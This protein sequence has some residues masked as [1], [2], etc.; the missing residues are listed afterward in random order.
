[1]QV[2]VHMG[3]HGLYSTTTEY[4]KFIR[5]WLNDGAAPDGSQ[6]LKPE[7][8]AMASENHL[9]GDMKITMLPGVIAA[10]SND[11]EFFPGMPKSWALSFMVNEEDAPTGR[12]AGSLAW[13][14]LANLFFWI[15]RRNGVGGFW[16]TQIL[17]FADPASIGGYLDLETAVYDS[18]RP[19]VST[20]MV[21]HWLTGEPVTRRWVPLSAISNNLTAAV[22][23][24][25]DG[26]FCSHHGVDWGSLDSVINDPDGPSRGASTLTMQTAKNLFLWPGRSYLRKA[27]EIPVALALERVWSKRDIMQAYLNIAEWGP[28]VFGAEAAAETHFHKPASQLT[29]REAALLATSLPNPILRDPGRPTRTQRT[30]AA[31]VLRRMATADQWLGCLRRN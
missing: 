5:M 13:A 17:P 6:V 4:M 18:L 3:G 19:P 25:E 27:L 24:S 16:A 2:G 23:M 31:I 30:L 15:D 14:G 11:A 22:I 26:Q 8:V 21:S 12:P 9:P 20:L 7:T 10:L 28:G 1:M 29:R